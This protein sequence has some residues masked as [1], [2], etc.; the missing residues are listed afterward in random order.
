MSA[1]LPTKY[2]SLQTLAAAGVH[3]PPTLLL[4]AKNLA[5]AELESFM[6]QHSG[7]YIVRSA[8]GAEDGANQSLAGHFYS[9][10]AVEAGGLE[11]E[12]KR[13]AAENIARA[14]SLPIEAPI[15][16]MVQPFYAAEMG[17]VAFTRWKYFPDCF[18]LE[19]AASPQAAVTGLD[20]HTVVVNSQGQAHYGSLNQ[21]E[22][23]VIKQL[24][25]VLK[26]LTQNYGAV[27]IEWLFTE[28]TGVVILQMRP[29][30]VAPNWLDMLPSHKIAAALPEK[31]WEQNELSENVGPLSPLSFSLLQALYA[32]ATTAL[33]PLGLKA[34]NIDW[35]HR[36][37]NG[38]LFCHE[39]GYKKF[40]AFKHWWSPARLAYQQRWQ[41]EALNTFL[42]SKPPSGFD[43][44]YLQTVFNWWLVSNV[45][46]VAQRQT[47]DPAVS[48][49][50]DYELGHLKSRLPES[51]MAQPSTWNQASLA[52]KQRFFQHLENL[53]QQVSKH[54]KA[55]W[56]SWEVYLN[57]PNTRVNEVVIAADRQAS[58]WAWPASRQAGEEGGRYLTDQ[59]EISGTAWNPLTHS[60]P[61][62]DAVYVGPYFDNQYV[63]FIPQLRGIIVGSGSALSHSAIVAREH[64]VPYLVD[65]TCTYRSGERI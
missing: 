57:A 19:V 35:L 29:I 45:Q 28:V 1:T 65:N 44:A 31:G 49:I 55:L 42:E 16:L 50:G 38:Q 6:R 36:A 20:T 43:A 64:Q 52:L 48:G 4:E 61:P 41:W 25:S 22:A 37:N 34:E 32:G 46:L 53:K 27:D 5:L 13:A 56:L 7:P 8:V 3:T 21:K 39:E 63:S 58:F 51:V 18:V 60:S 2:T 62:P 9:S 26:P 14:E 11:A 17:G 24:I 54:P 33:Q 10:E 23:V 12:I 47:A 15:F 40:F 30:T 59:R